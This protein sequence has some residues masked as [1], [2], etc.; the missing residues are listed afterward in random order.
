MMISVPIWAY[1]WFIPL[2]AFNL[3]S[4]KR[5]DHK[6]YFVTK[7]EYKSKFNMMDNQF[8]FKSI[9]YAVAFAMTL[10]L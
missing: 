4:F 3:R 10:I 5:K 7:H 6:I 8:K 2:I 1:I 9:I